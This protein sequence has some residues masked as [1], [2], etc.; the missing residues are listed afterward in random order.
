VCIGSQVAN[1]EN[2][3][4][5]LDVYRSPTMVDVTCVVIPHL[6]C[7]EAAFEHAVRTLCAAHSSQGLYSDTAGSVDI[8]P[9]YMKFDKD[10]YMLFP[11]TE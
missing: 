1:N 10:F 9:S 5:P 2:D 11:Q 3:H 8:R 7:S 4:R 6:R